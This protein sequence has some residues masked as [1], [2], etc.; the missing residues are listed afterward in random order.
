MRFVALAI[1]HAMRM[2]VLSSMACSVLQYFSTLSRKRQ[3]FRKNVIEHKMR[4][5]GVC[6]QKKN[7]DSLLNF[8]HRASSI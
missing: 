8:R 6:N 2:R 7:F 5:E 1:Q 4:S 3:D